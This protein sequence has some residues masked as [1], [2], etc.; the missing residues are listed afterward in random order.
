MINIV[1]MKKLKYG[2]SILQNFLDMIENIITKIG[3]ANKR[4][5]RKIITWPNSTELTVL[6]VNDCNNNNTRV[7]NK[8]NRIQDKEN[9]FL[10]TLD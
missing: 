3:I 9:P 6:S 2:R 4:P 5:N 8:N 7:L 10:I 1:N